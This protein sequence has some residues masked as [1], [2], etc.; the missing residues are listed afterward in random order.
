M[1]WS[2]WCCGCCGCYGCSF[3]TTSAASAT[4]MC[5]ALH[6]GP[7][8]RVHLQAR[9]WSEPLHPA[10][11]YGRGCKGGAWREASQVRV[12]CQRGAGRRHPQH[13]AR[14]LRGQRC[15]GACPPAWLQWE[16]QRL[17]SGS[18]LHRSW[19]SWRRRPQRHWPRWCTLT[20]FA[21]G[22]RAAHCR[23]RGACC[24]TFECAS[25][26]RSCLLPASDWPPCR[27]KRPCMCRTP[28]SQRCP[29]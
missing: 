21:C 29:P 17:S 28:A 19:G 12:T 6:L 4:G 27:C 25:C 5:A 11:I 1:V 2:G 20:S 7:P 15:G 16:L 3:V 23:L 13:C 24:A 22:Q 18:L 26:P 14:A 9:R 8:L 10:H